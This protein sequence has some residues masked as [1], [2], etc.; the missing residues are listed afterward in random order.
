MLKQHDVDYGELPGWQ[1]HG[2]AVY[3]GQDEGRGAH[4]VI[5]LRLPQAEHYP[6]YLAR[7]LI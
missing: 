2:S 3:M 6:E 5:D 4:L 1:R 7:H